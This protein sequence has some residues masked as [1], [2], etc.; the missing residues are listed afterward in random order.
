[1]KNLLIA[2]LSL[3]FV[4]SSGCGIS[5]IDPIEPGINLFLKWK[6]GE[7]HKYYLYSSDT[8]YRAMK[9]SCRKLGYEIERDDP[10]TEDHSY[11]VIAGS[12]DRFKIKVR[13]VEE[14]VSKLS[15]RI[16]F[17]GDKPYAELIF[18]EVDGELSVIEF[19]PQGNPKAKKRRYSN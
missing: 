17:W 3:A 8:V 12:N 18:K 5:P 11:Y 7:G 15:V 19:D 14:N 4:F 1:M 13:S 9:R 6:E 2:F 10:P 16:N